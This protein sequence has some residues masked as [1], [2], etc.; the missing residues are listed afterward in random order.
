MDTPRT[1]GIH[2]IPVEGREFED[3]IDGYFPLVVSIRQLLERHSFASA[4]ISLSHAP[5]MHLEGLGSEA[6]VPLRLNPD[7][8]VGQIEDM[9]LLATCFEGQLL[10]CGVG[11]WSWMTNGVVEGRFF[12]SSY[13]L[14]EPAYI[15]GLGL[16]AGPM[17]MG[18]FVTVKSVNFSARFKLLTLSSC[19]D[20]DSSAFNCHARSKLWGIEHT[21]NAIVKRTSRNVCAGEIL[22]GM[23]LSERLKPGFEYLLVDT[24]KPTTIHSE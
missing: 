14:A 3:T 6:P 1:V 16:A 23:T 22:S 17:S 11:E 18:R 4:F 12:S 15:C 20:E 13:R 10:L 2:C 8:K 21:E 9:L 24:D 7:A 5:F 19:F